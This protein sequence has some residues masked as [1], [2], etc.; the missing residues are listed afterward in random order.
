ML[1]RGPVGRLAAGLASAALLTLTFP[2]AGCG[3]L[4]WIALVP[5]LLACRGLRPRAAFLVA[6]P[7]GMAAA[8]GIYSWILEIDIHGY[9]VLL[10]ALWLG[11]FPAVWSAGVALLA[12]SRVPLL[13]T[14]PA[15]WVAADWVKAHAGFMAVPWATLAHA[16]H[17]NLALLQTATLA[18]EYGVTFLVVLA[19]V[20]LAEAIA[21]RR[22]GRG[23][24]AVA[25][26]LAAAHLLG[27]AVLARSADGPAVR[28][29][30]I[31][32]SILISER[33]TP[34]G[35]EESY[36]RLLRLTQETAA[37]RPALIAWPETAIRDLGREQGM[38]DRIQG[39]VDT[40]GI[41]LVVGT[42]E[43]MKFT[44]QDETD[45]PLEYRAFNSAYVFRPGRAPDPPY[46]KIILVP[47]AEYLPLE[48]YVHWPS[49]F[50]TGLYPSIAGDRLQEFRLDDG[51]AFTI[52]ICWEGV[53]A[54]LIRPSVRAGARLLVQINNANHFNHSAAEP[55]HLLVTVLRAV[56][57]R[58]AVVVSSNSGP[59]AIID[60]YGR[61]LEQIP[62]L[63]TAAAISRTVPLASGGTLYSRLGDWFVALAGLLALI[64]LGD[65]LIRPGQRDPGRA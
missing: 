26:V 43:F 45:L 47:F 27:W 10:L 22:L 6:L 2:K 37:S 5:L 24:L 31:Q 60:P 8:L 55:Q 38:S 59:S 18:G 14:A 4:G 32:P 52:R 63:F 54:D 16:Q 51:T 56:E 11:L 53:F 1:T 41:P 46:R 34:A 65:A 30:A 44:R 13:L 29:A 40:M 62:E 57:N 42:S 36:R 50:A 33:A 15:L 28:V 20:A 64:G 17:R 35:R 21:R 7:A 25:G 12:R 61:V 49:W 48:G 23:T 39:L 19:N 9:Q 58:L 3:W